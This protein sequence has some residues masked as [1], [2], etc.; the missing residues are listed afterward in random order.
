MG[1]YYSGSWTGKA[2]WQHSGKISRWSDVDQ[3]RQV[4]PLKELFYAKASIPT[5]SWRFSILVEMKLLGLGM[6]CW[7]MIKPWSIPDTEETT[8]LCNWFDDLQRLDWTPRVSIQSLFPSISRFC[9]WL[10]V[11]STKLVLTTL[12]QIMKKSCYSMCW[13]TSNSSSHGNYTGC[14]RELIVSYFRGNMGLLWGNDFFMP[15]DAKIA[16]VDLTPNL[17]HIIEDLTT[18]IDVVTDSDNNIYF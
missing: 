9:S 18:A 3:D 8:E 5:T 7:G 2:G 16:K 17:E 14:R 12:N 6:V 13:K 1:I 11:H 15:G 10:R 4:D